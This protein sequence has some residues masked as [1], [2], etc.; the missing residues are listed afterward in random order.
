ME[1]SDGMIGAAASTGRAQCAR[2]VTS[3]QLGL[4]EAALGKK[5][6]KCVLC[7]PVLDIRNGK[8]LAVICCINKHNE[9]EDSLFSEPNFTIN[10]E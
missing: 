6:A 4:H 1:M 8:V 10:D 9:S 3:L 7:Q 5:V 2:E